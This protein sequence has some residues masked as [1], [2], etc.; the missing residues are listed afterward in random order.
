MF[1]INYNIKAWTL[2]QKFVFEK[3]VTADQSIDCQWIVLCTK[4]FGYW[5]C[6]FDIQC[7]R[8]YPYVRCILKKV[9]GIKTKINVLL[10]PNQPII[11]KWSER[12]IGDFFHYKAWMWMKQLAKTSVWW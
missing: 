5:L 8:H 6:V 2:E 7:I 3:C 1:G 9:N 10:K 11:R 4:M 12:N